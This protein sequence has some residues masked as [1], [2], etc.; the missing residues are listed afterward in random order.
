[1]KKRAAKK[2]KK[3]AVRSGAGAKDLVYPFGQGNPFQPGLYTSGFIETSVAPA[4]VPS[5]GEAMKK[6]QGR[7]KSCKCRA[8]PEEKPAAPAETTD[9]VLFWFG[10]AVAS[11]YFAALAGAIYI[12]M[13]GRPW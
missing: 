11:A 5:D 3:K 7:C 9:S 1:M 13:R 2:P 8:A 10:A 6:S 4:P 12:I